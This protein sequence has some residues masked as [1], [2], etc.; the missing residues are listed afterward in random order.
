MFSNAIERLCVETIP[1][2]VR[3]GTRRGG[4]RPSSGQPME[5][6][7][8][9]PARGCGPYRELDDPVGLTNT[10]ADA[11]A[12]AHREKRPAPTGRLAEPVGIAKVSLM[13]NRVGQSP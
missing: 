11:L 3:D 1:K 4:A 2:L 13:I 12:S 6:S 8:R 10:S 7:N 5:I 9:W